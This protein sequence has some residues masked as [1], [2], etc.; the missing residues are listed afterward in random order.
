MKTHDADGSV[1]CSLFVSLLKKKK[2]TFVGLVTVIAQEIPEA[3][4]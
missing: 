3:V 2:L 4:E 1:I